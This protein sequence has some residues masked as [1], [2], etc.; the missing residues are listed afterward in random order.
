[1]KPAIVFD[2]GKVLVDFDYQI[3]ARKIAARSTKHLPDF[4]KFLGSSEILARFESGVLNRRQFFDEMKDFTGFKGDIEEFA[5][6]FADIFLPIPP[7]IE[8]HA[9][10][11][12]RGFQ[13]YIFSNTNDIAVEHI[14]HN[15]PFFA[16]FDGYI[17]SY[18]VGAMKPQPKIYEA[19]EKLCGHKGKDIIYIDD[20][21]ENIDT[22]AARGWSAILHE[23]PEKTRDTLKKLL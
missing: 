18:E 7:M 6:D 19:M 20:R 23:L 4:H 5:G 12:Q 1:M 10:L 15:F 9:E 11:R 17:Y 14:R 8:L 21:P 22:G 3:G 13:T 16:N 2:L